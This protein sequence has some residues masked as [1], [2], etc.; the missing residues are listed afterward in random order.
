MAVGTVN[1]KGNNNV[2]RAVC[3]M[4]A[5]TANT[6]APT[7]TSAGTASTQGVPCYPTSGYIS[8]EDGAFFQCEYPDLA[9]LM[10]SSSAGSGTMSGTFTLWGHKQATGCWYPV[11]VIILAETASDVIRYQ[12][13][14]TNLGHYDRLFLQLASV[15]GT[16]TAFEA[17]MVTARKG[18]G[19]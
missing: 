13:V 7:D 10:I 5:Q 8:S 11:A 18:G 14:F 6:G 16:S 15:D 9:T 4:T 12:Q 19:A 1:L 17:Y 3:L 2:K